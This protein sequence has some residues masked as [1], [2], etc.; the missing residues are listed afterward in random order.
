M[1]EHLAEHGVYLHFEIETNPERVQIQMLDK[2]GR[3][4]GEVPSLRLL[5]AL[6][7]GEGLLLDISHLG[8]RRPDGPPS[9]S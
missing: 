2:N 3:A 1:V 5:E 4:L 8:S 6:S 7:D 9:C